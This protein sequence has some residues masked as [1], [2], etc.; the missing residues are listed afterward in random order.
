MFEI[1]LVDDEKEMLIGLEKILSSRQ[2]FKITA[3]QDPVDRTWPRRPT[4]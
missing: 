4:R 2:N 1:L 3:Q